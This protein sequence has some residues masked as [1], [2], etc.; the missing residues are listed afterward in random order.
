MV[1]FHSVGKCQAKDPVLCRFHGVPVSG[2]ALALYE[3]FLAQKGGDG[4]G[5]GLSASE[6]AL[7]SS[8]RWDGECPGWFEGFVAGA[9][10]REF[11]GCVPELLDVVDSPVGRLAV[12]WEGVSQDVKDEAVLDSGYC[13]QSIQFRSWESGEVLG[14]VK[15]SSMNEESF[16][17]SFGDDELAEFRYADRYRGVNCGFADVAVSG[18]GRF[19]L[20]DRGLF[21]EDLLVKKRQV[22]LAVQ[23]YGKMGDSSTVVYDEDGKSLMSYQVSEDHVPSDVK[24]DA[25]LQVFREQIAVE[26]RE[27][28][29]FFEVPYIDYSRVSESLKGKGFGSALYVFAARRLAVDGKVLRGS[30]IQTEEAKALWGRLGKLFPGRVSFL[31]SSYRGEVKVNPVLDFRGSVESPV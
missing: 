19:L 29:A 23:Q 2:G 24:V 5:G 7:V 21:G 9:A 31:S 6:R 16:R 26:M 13:L 4:L 20:G 14:F 25:D 28:Q 18:P 8:L 3:S 1:G 10:G 15:V 12:V 17:V 30:G 11:G 22:W 27:K